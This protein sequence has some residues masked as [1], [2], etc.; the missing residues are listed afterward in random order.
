MIPFGLRNAV[1][2]YQR[3]TVTLSLDLMH[4]EIEV[5]V[6]DMIVKVRGVAEHVKDLRKLFQLKIES[7][8]MYLRSYIRKAAGVCYE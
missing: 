5:Y 4:K 7:I 3:A 1:A 8:Q 6:D 2:T